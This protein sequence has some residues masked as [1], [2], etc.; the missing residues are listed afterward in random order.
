MELSI[1]EYIRSKKFALRNAAII[2]C[3]TFKYAKINYTVK[4]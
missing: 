4:P 1:G 3:S 2:G